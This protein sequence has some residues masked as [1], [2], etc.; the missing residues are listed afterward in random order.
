MAATNSKSNVATITQEEDIV[1]TRIIDAP[2][3]LVF[4]AW[5]DPEY[6]VHW[7]G[8][9]G[10]TTPS[11]KVDLRPGGI[12]HFCMRSPDG[13]DFWGR[14]IYHEITEPEKIVYTDSFSD[15]EGNLVEPERY[16]M[17]RDFPSE[18]LVTVTFGKLKGKTELTM[19]HAVMESVPERDEMKQGWTE[20]FDRLNEYLEKVGAGK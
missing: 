11:C 7:W 8:P 2:R 5:T 18:T 4:R 15:E 3:D 17:S 16:G 14:G 1:I 13:R 10:F 9:K 20:M 12:F 6:L 19:H